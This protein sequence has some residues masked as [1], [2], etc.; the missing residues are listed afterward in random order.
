MQRFLFQSWY[1]LSEIDNILAN[2]LKASAN[3]SIQNDLYNYDL[4]DITRQMIQNKI[5]QLY[6]KIVDS[7]N[8]RNITEFVSYTNYFAD[9]LHDLERILSTNDQFLLGKWLES[10]KKLAVA[11][12]DEVEVYEL[13][14]RNQITIWGPTG[15]VYDYAMKQWS[16]MIVD[17]CLPRWKIFFEEMRKSLRTNEYFNETE[18]KRVIF[19]SIEE[20]F[21][22]ADKLYAV[23]GRG[24]SIEIAREIYEKW[25]LIFTN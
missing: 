21:M 10:A 25:K 2:F 15:Q 7:F 19:E 13:N 14:A 24:S 20:P 12:N 1:N 22:Y 16:G 3:V 23:K 4:V 18:C 17:Y 8:N 11:T 9:L 6:V 5:E